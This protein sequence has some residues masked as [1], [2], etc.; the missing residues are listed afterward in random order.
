VLL[1]GSS[2]HASAD[3]LRAQSPVVDVGQVVAGDT[4]VATFVLAND[5]QR[6]IRILRAAPS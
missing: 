6:D 2:V 1:T 5:S 4:A 3:G